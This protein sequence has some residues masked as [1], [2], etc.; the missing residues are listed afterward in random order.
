FGLLV[1]MG[2]AFVAIVARLTW[3]Q[4]IGP[5]QYLAV[6]SSEW[7]HTVTLAAERG[8]IVDRAG[9]ELAI[10]IPQTTLYADPPLVTDPGGEAARLSP[11]L[12]Q[13][14]A[15]LQARLTEHNRFTYL[16]RTVDSATAAKVKALNLPGIYSL[17][18]P[19]RFY[20]AGQLARPLVGVTGTDG[21]GLGGLE[22]KYQ[23][24]LEGQPGKL[25]E[26]TDPSG[27]Q[28]AGGLQQFQAPVAG[29]DL[30]LTLDDSLQYDAE[31]AL[32]QAIVAANA[33]S[34]IAVLMDRKTGDILAD[35]Q[36]SMPGP[37][38]ATTPAVPVDIPPPTGT[39][40][41]STGSQPV[42]SPSASSFT[43][44]YEPGSVNKLVTLSGALQ[45][46]SITP[47]STFTIPNTYDVAGTPIHD[48]E[49]HGTEHWNVT[50][51][52]TNSSNIGTLQ[53]AQKLGKT[54]I[55]GTIA[56]FGEGKKTDIGFPGE[57]A[58]ILPSY[59]SGT[60]LADVSFGQGVSVTAMQVLAAY[61]AIA[62]DGMYVAPR[63]VAGTIDKTGAEHA[64]PVTPG[65]RVVSST[66]AKQMT[67]MLDE[68][69]RVGTG[70]AANLNPYTVAGK[71][72][73]ASIPS[74][75]GGYEAGH[76][77]ASF[78]GFVPA[79]N[80]SVTAM[81]VINDTP[82]FGAAASAPTFA[83]LARDT[84]QALKVPP[85]P[86]APP[87]P[88]VPQ[89]NTATAT[90]AGESAGTALPGLS[91]TPSVPTTAPTPPATPSVPPTAPNPPA[92]PSGATTTTPASKAP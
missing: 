4:G 75:T 71:T 12:G 28:I 87:A 45:Q 32:A 5:N 84:L 17:Q 78:A 57:S 1:V 43:Q 47:S 86:K 61:N 20:P 76:Y 55:L 2:V 73:T 16:A 18:E 25:V 41:A 27:H 53:I 34:G 67:T 26:Q 82:D 38:T 9:N 31:Q 14:P 91:A 65:H 56:G 92:A 63:L 21:T 49:S 19:K 74:S 88:G 22:A 52:L 8:S 24:I 37:G 68:V 10:S 79:E 59:W 6:G 40:P 85:E 3:L 60:T 13:T 66:V 77:V 48:A 51:I 7:T 42:E 72:G 44:V 64:T 70:Q 83:T 89:T 33:K 36:L 69:V 58:G 11:A 50:D 30:V 35:A 29:Q 90:A 39:P 46:G 80:P 81:V 54:G 62:N 15:Q 23:S